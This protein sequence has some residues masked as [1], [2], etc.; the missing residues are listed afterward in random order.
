MEAR[1]S[2]GCAPNP[3]NQGRGRPPQLILPPTHPSSLGGRHP[4]TATLPPPSISLASFLTPA[5]QPPQDCDV[6]ERFPPL[7]TERVELTAAE[8]LSQTPPATLFACRSHRS[9]PDSTALS[10]ETGTDG[11]SPISGSPKPQH[12]SVALFG[13]FDGHGGVECSNFMAER[14]GEIL[15]SHPRLQEVMNSGWFSFSPTERWAARQRVL[16]LGRDQREA[17]PEGDDGVKTMRETLGRRE[18]SGDS[19]VEGGENPSSH[20]RPHPRP[21]VEDGS[22]IP[23][24]EEEEEVE[25]EEERTEEEFV[26]IVSS[27]FRDAFMLAETLWL[28]LAGHLQLMS[29]TTAALVMVLG[30]RVWV[31]NVGDSE[32][33]L[34]IRGQAQ[35]L[36]TVHSPLR[37]P[38]EAARVLRT[39]GR[40]IEGR[41][42]NPLV[43]CEFLSSGI[44]MLEDVVLSL[45]FSSFPSDRPY[46]FFPSF[47]SP[48]C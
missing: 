23:S 39:G 4:M 48:L 22:F 46:L 28:S 30:R 6:S 17:I 38:V 41:V 42:M 43:E 29:G 15:L 9:S 45:L 26:R 20:P 24:E 7:L 34:S 3:T 8:E 47:P 13:V 5:T 2:D 40:L 12:P 35:K 33:V 10:G 14:L 25:E 37:N 36:T 44:G 19:L 1:P 16:S 21:D 31:G 11:T 32:V 27:A 18:T